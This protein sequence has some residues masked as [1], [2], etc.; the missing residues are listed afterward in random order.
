MIQHY[1]NSCQQKKNAT[2]YK[3]NHINPRNTISI[4]KALEV[5]GAFGKTPVKS[6]YSSWRKWTIT[7]YLENKHPHNSQPACSAKN[8][9]CLKQNTHNQRF[10]GTGSLATG[11]SKQWKQLIDSLDTQWS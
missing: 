3:L 5:G 10:L 2:E 6:Y 11:Y 4:F 1:D 8:P 7:T 9:V